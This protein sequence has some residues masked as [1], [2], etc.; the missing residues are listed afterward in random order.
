MPAPRVSIRTVLFDLD[1]TLADTAPD[2]ARALNALRAEQGLGPLPDAVIRPVVSHGSS[3]LVS[4]GLGAAAQDPHFDALRERFLAL[5]AARLA[6]DTR[7]FPGMAALL[8]ALEEQGRRWGVVTNKPAWL[9]EPLIEA[10]G[11]AQRAACTVS[12]DSTRYRK[13]HPAPLLLA[14][15]DCAA[16][17]PQCLYVGDHRRDIEAGRNAGMHTLVALFGYLGTDDAPGAW[18]ADG[19]VDSPAGIMDWI[20]AAE[21][22]GPVTAPHA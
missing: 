20:A 9:T 18:G 4:L 19:M 6:V 2:I 11:L 13:P 22:G 10:L 1:G 14:C 17:P 21:A 16:T 12:G 15:R 8:C 3:A 5:Y 7:L